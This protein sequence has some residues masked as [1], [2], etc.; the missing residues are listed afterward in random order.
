MRKGFTLVELIF[1]IVIIGILA[2]AAI[3]RFQNLKQHAEANNVIKTVMDSASA[4]PA[5]AVNKK[6]LENNNS[7]QL[8]DIL[9]L[10]SGNWRLADSK[11]TYYY[12]DNNG[13][14]Y[15]VSLIEFNLTARTVTVGIDCTKFAD[16]KSREF[17]TEELNATEYNQTITF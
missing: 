1:V 8:K 7:F 9:T 15:N 16:E 2:A 6:D 17:C 13:T 3:P 5:A 10:K 14:D 11:N 12:V 4:V